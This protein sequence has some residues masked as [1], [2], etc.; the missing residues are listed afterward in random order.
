MTR[1]II[2]RVIFYP[3]HGPGY[4][5]TLLSLKPNLKEIK[6]HKSVL[7][8][9]A[10]YPLKGSGLFIDQIVRLNKFD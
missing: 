6:N 4:S 9:S 2:F 1:V 5:T 8:A 10:Q 7:I 3:A